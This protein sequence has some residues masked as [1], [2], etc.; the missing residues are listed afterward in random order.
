MG[1]LPHNLPQGLGNECAV[2]LSRSLSL[3]AL[4]MIWG[5]QRTLLMMETREL[6]LIFMIFI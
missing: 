5:S 1:L 3:H 2:V 6:L 4:K